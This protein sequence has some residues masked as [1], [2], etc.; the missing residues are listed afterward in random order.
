VLIESV[1]KQAGGQAGVGEVAQQGRS[2][3]RPSEVSMLDTPLTPSWGTTAAPAR[4]PWA[5]QAVAHTRNHCG[6]ARKPAISPMPPFQLSSM[7]GFLRFRALA[8]PPQPLSG[9]PAAWPRPLPRSCPV[10][11]SWGLASSSH[12]GRPAPPQPVLEGT[13]TLR[14]AGAASGGLASRAAAGLLPPPHAHPPPRCH[15]RA[16]PSETCPH[17]LRQSKLHPPLF[18]PPA[19]PS[20]LDFDSRR[21]RGGFPAAA[22]T[23]SNSDSRCFPPPQVAAA[24]SPEHGSADSKRPSAEGEAYKQ[25]ESKSEQQAR[26]RG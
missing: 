6:G 24:T 3:S 13:T 11:T 12:G 26:C 25:E 7:G 9:P 19:V 16:L 17:L 15:P 20:G 22:D 4:P 1:C 8:G 21:P 23:S 14:Q 10:P 18:T 2:S 5:L